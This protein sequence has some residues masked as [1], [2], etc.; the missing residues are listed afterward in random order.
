MISFARLVA[1][2]AACAACSACSAND[3]VPAPLISSIVP[4]HAPAG[5]VVTIAGSYFCQR[6]QNGSNEDPNCDIVGTVH[7]GQ[8]PGTPSSW[9]DTSIMVEVPPGVAGTVDVTITALGK[10]SNSV[11]FTAD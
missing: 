4:S 3:D 1:A 9:M 10:T 8:A 11:S 5:S 2:L 6:P 7:F